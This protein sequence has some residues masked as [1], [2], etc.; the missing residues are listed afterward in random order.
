MIEHDVGVYGPTVPT[1]AIGAGMF[2][3]IQTGF[4]HPYGFYAS[5]DALGISH[6]RWPGGTLAEERPEVY[7]LDIEGLFDAT[8][9]YS[10][11][12][13]RVRSDPESLFQ[14]AIERGAYVTLILPTARYAADI[15]LGAEHVA[16]LVTDLLSGAYGPLPE[17]LILE[18]GNEYSFRA[19]FANNPTLYGVVA[20]RFIEVITG[21][22]ADSGLGDQ[23]EIAVQ[24]GVTTT[25]D[26]AIRSSIEWENLAAI[27]HLTFHH[28]PISLRNAH[29]ADVTDDLSSVG[30]TRF[31]L[32]SDRETAWTKDIV[33]AGGLHPSLYLSAWTVGEAALSASEV[34]LRF[35]DYGL[36]AASTAL[37][38]LYNYTRIGTDLAAVWGVDVVNLNH[39]S[40]WEDVE[41]TITPLGAIVGMMAETLIGAVALPGAEGFDRSD[42]ANVYTFLAEDRVVLYAISNQ[43]AETLIINTAGVSPTWSLSARV[44]GS[45]LPADAPGHLSAAELRLLE[46]A[47]IS[48][49]FPTWAGTSLSFDVDQA[50][51]ITE[52]VID[53]PEGAFW[54]TFGDDI[55]TATDMRHD[56]LGLDGNDTLIG[57]WRN[58]AL[59]AGDGNDVLSGGGGTN[60]LWGGEGSDVFQFKELVANDRIWDFNPSED[61]LDFST[62]AG[63]LTPDGAE[64]GYMLAS[65]LGWIDTEAWISVSATTSLDGV[66][67]EVSTGL[68]VEID[69]FLSGID[70]SELVLEH[71]IFF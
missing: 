7:G 1:D 9:L 64:P 69:V 17:R 71:F 53:V 62:L 10:P 58:N 15:E 39:L 51:E 16:S 3:A 24:L 55:L 27:S 5:T 23:I 40:L 44:L 48:P 46:E 25:D 13:E 49:V 43:P 35:Q 41:L 54:G 21:T 6:F 36:P 30:K 20:N 26:D 19:E 67:V 4:R 57:D 47:S 38:L 60:D 70:A 42:R 68:G 2:G 33:A 65:L 11:D 12:A 66:K 45:V 56:L 37:D 34:D 63:R 22:I 18:I 28:L 61:V 50:F 14:A 29:R 52:I 59:V 32:V 31:E 8:Y